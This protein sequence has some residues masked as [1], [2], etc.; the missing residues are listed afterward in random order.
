MHR[1]LLYNICIEGLANSV[2]DDFKKELRQYWFHRYSRS[3]G[4]V[5]STGFEHI[6]VGEIQFGTEV[7]GSQNWINFYFKEKSGT[8]VYGPYRRRRC[9]VW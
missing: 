9:E 5:D 6:F 1:H 4:P 8:F 3:G 7:I 2:D